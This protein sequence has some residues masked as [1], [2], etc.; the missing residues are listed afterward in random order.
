MLELSEV[1]WRA[2]LSVLLLGILELLEDFVLVV[3]HREAFQVVN[4]LH[5][6]AK[7]FQERLEALAVLVDPEQLVH[8]ADAIDL[9]RAIREQVVVLHQRIHAVDPQA[10]AEDF[11][12]YRIVVR[13]D[14]QPAALLE[15]LFQQLRLS[16]QHD[17]L[18]L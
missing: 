14:A 15:R 7:H 10:V 3:L 6:R 5:L 8:V 11:G 18:Q 16:V 1:V 2:Q 13:V 9:Q 17:E 12:V 4:V